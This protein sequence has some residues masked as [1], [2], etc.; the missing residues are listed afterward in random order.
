MA[1]ASQAAIGTR[2]RVVIVEDSPRIRE[3]LEEAL[4]ELGN[5]AIAGCAETEAQALDLL[6][7]DEWDLALLDLQLKQGNGLRVL[8]ALG[9]G[10]RRMHGKIA[11]FTSYSFPQYKK[12]AFELGADYFFDKAREFH[13]MLEVV[14]QLARARRPRPQMSV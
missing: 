6:N 14:A 10:V 1:P 4:A 13:R 8:K 5:V 11:V 2:L 9:D 7:N 3:H 12:R